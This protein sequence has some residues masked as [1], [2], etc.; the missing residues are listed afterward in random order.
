MDMN[1]FLKN[2]YSSTALLWW[3]WSWSTPGSWLGMPFK[4]DSM[5]ELGAA[6]GQTVGQLY[7][8]VPNYTRYCQ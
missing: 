1:R 5:L 3:C 8:V 2:W 6:N 7:K 4:V